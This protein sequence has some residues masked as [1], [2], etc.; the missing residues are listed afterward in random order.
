MQLMP[1]KRCDNGSALC[2]KQLTLQGR[3]RRHHSVRLQRQYETL[4][5]VEPKWTGNALG[6]PFTI[7]NYVLLR[8]NVETYCV[9]WCDRGGVTKRQ[10]SRCL[11]QRIILHHFMT[12]NYP[13]PGMCAVQYVL[14]QMLH[15]RS[16]SESTLQTFAFIIIRCCNRAQGNKQLSKPGKER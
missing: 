1:H 6:A 11:T 16:Q 4:V 12:K 5:L 3:K 15:S 2:I 10:W 9:V 13:Y 7:G 8:C 14:I